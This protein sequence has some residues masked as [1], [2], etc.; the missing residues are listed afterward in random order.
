[1]SAPNQATRKVAKHRVGTAPVL[2]TPATSS[3]KVD[4]YNHDASRVAAEYIQEIQPSVLL[5]LLDR[6]EELEREVSACAEFL[7]QGALSPPPS[8]ETQ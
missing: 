1:M 8:K 5:S 2:N 3:E 6:I 4:G 7:N